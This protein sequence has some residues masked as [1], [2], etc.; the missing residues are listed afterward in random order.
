MSTKK[1]LTDKQWRELKPACQAA[2]KGV[3]DSLRAWVQT[4][5]G[6]ATVG[7]C[8]KRYAAARKSRAMKD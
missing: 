8:N 1:K 7:R 3:E 4:P 6:K 5:Q 2:A